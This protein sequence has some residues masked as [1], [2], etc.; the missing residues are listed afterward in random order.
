MTILSPSILAGNHINIME[1]V[2][3]IEKGGGDG[4]HVD[5]M[6]GHYVKNLTFGPKT[7]EDLRKFTTLPIDVHLEM[8]RQEEFIDC[9]IEAGADLITIQYESC[10]HPLRAI[11][12]VK[13]KGCQ[14]SM[15]F[16]PTT[17]LE[18]LQY[19][20]HEL[21]QINLMS[22]EPGFGGQTFREEIFKKIEC[23]KNQ[24]DKKRLNTIIAVDGGVNEKNIFMLQQ[25]GA[26]NMIVGSRVFENNEI[27][28]NIK[29]LKELVTHK[30][31]EEEKVQ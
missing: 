31:V 22:V 15:A 11:Q 6:D 21:D 13:A 16:A 9:F 27:E 5:I 10:E 3:K 20:I 23:V 28:K 18:T 26:E 30:T 24:I 7:I 2:K 17:H 4:I 1:E 12:Q 25:C 8:Y 19:F 29:L 14:V